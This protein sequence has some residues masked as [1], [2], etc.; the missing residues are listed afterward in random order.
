MSFKSNSIPYIGKSSQRISLI[1]TKFDAIML[2]IEMVDHDLETISTMLEGDQ[3]RNL[4]TNTIT[5]FNEDGGIY[6]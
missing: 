3:L 2:E 4:E 6:H 1:N 5:T